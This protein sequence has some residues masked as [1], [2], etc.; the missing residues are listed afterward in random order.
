MK[1]KFAFLAA[2]FII[3]AGCIQKRISAYTY[4][5]SYDIEDPDKMRQDF[6]SYKNALFQ[7]VL[8]YKF[9]VNADAYVNNFDTASQN[10]AGSKYSFDTLCVLMRVKNT[11]L[12]YKFDRFS[13]NAQLIDKGI[14]DTLSIGLKFTID[15]I[16]KKS[17]I[18]IKSARDVVINRIP[19]K[20]I[21]STISVENNTGTLSMF[22]LKNKDLISV[23]N[24]NNQIKNIDGVY[25]FAGYL[26]SMSNNPNKEGVIIT[27]YNRIDSKTASICESLYL[28]TLR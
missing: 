12:F 27:K 22:Y 21:D 24:I 11:K 6:I 15:S 10:N 19:F 2:L 23:F 14:T 20:R 1:K 4:T 7:F 5:L 17:R 3:S 16:E 18:S 26:F 13:A 25:S 28:K 8:H 9:E